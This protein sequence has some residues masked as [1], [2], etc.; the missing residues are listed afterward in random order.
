MT[1]ENT[2]EFQGTDLPL[3]GRAFLWFAV[4]QVVMYL[5]HVQVDSLNH[6]EDIIYIYSLIRFPWIINFVSHM[7]HNL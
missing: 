1:P 7:S 3:P 5:S 2:D 6:A 4:S